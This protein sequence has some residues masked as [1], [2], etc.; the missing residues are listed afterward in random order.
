MPCQYRISAK[1]CQYIPNFHGAGI[2]GRAKN[3]LT[4]RLK[5]EGISDTD[6]A[7]CQEAWQSDRMTTI[8]DF[9]VFYNN[10]DVVPFLK[11]I[12]Q[13]FAFYQQQDIVCL[14]M[15]LAFRV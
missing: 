5:N 15:E 6:Y 12:D 2:V 8:R 4:Y 13:Q 10:R 1:Q 7:I 3:M 14:K 9:F 11:A